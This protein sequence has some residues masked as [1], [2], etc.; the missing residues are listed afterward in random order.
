MFQ[1]PKIVY[2][3]SMYHLFVIFSFPQV[4]KTESI[5]VEDLARA[6]NIS[7]LLA[8]ER[9]STAE[10]LGKICRDES[11]EGLRFYPNKFLSVQ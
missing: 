9:L 7:L 11:I 10:R 3:G 8:Q 6:L 2:F 5:G 1:L 4:E